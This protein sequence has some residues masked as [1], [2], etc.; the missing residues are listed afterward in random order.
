MKPCFQVPIEITVSELPTTETDIS[1]TA[2]GSIPVTVDQIL[3]DPIVTSTFSDALG[4]G[5]F[6]LFVIIL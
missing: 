1:D 6:S 3:S 4:S 2:F 5:L